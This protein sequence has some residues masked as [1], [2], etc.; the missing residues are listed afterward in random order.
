MPR[1][2]SLIESLASDCGMAPITPAATRSAARGRRRLVG[3]FLWSVGSAGLQLP[4]LL[5][6]N[7]VLPRAPT[8][9]LLWG[10]AGTPGERV[11]AV[12]RGAGGEPVENAS[13]VVDARGRW[14]VSLSP[15]PA[16]VTPHALHITAPSCPR[17]LL[18]ENVLFGDVWLCAGQSN[19]EMSYDQALHAARDWRAAQRVAVWR[20]VRVL[21]VTFA[22]RDEP[23]DD[24]RTAGWQ[25]THNMRTVRHF[26]ALGFM[27]GWRLWEALGGRVPVGLIQATRGGQEIQCFAPPAALADRTCG[28]TRDT[29]GGPPAAAAAAAWW[30]GGAD[31]GADGGAG[32]GTA[33]AAL[34]A[35]NRTRASKMWFG[36]FHPL[37][38]LAL[39]GVL[40]YHGEADHARP[41]EYSCTFPA[42][43]AAFRRELRHARI[44][45]GAG[46]LPF[47]FV[48]LAAYAPLDFSAVRLAQ[49]AALRLPAVGYATALDLGDPSA[50]LGGATLIG[51][52]PRHKRP[53]ARRLLAVVLAVAYGRRGVLTSGPVLARAK[54]TPERDR[55]TLHFLPD[56]AR[57]GLRAAGTLGCDACCGRSPFEVLPRGERAAWARAPFELVAEPSGNGSAVVV[58]GARNAVA[59]RYAFEPYPQCALYNGR[60]TPGPNHTAGEF[61]AGPFVLELER[62]G[63][64]GSVMPLGTVSDV[65]RRA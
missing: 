53:L 27:A 62:D 52:H 11:L 12:L 30:L 7:A 24:V 63:P 4:R 58:S 46:A 33:T 16:S 45:G 8:A 50:P 15:R 64:T 22:A 23:A 32:N 31:G 6:N 37:R 49:L 60:G 10:H 47:V 54:R 35:V 65:Q 21:G 44:E 3:V 20:G 48:Q 51:I 36:M 42:L 9:P 1:G 2:K 56:S 40:W 57:G 61:A 55:I 18:V 28:G 25:L 39:S 41:R 5:S 29:A 13:A 19:M 43:V 34:P 26:S 38:A 59:L 14:S 17:G